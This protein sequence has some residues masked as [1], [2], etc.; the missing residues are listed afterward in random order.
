MF[1]PPTSGTRRTWQ[2]HKGNL[3]PGAPSSSQGIPPH[4][5]E[6]QLSSA[7]HKPS[8]RSG[9]AMQQRNAFTLI[10]L[11]VVIAIIAI[12]AAILLPVFAQARDKA[13]QSACLSNTRQIGTAIT[14]YTQ[15]Y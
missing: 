15:D 1:S 11:L 5:A 4:Q 6:P 9:N 7:D 12:L 3:N 8:R 10:E 13:R 14:L 2:L